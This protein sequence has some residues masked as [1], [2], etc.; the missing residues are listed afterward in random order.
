MVKLTKYLGDDNRKHLT[1][2]MVIAVPIFQG[3][4][5]ELMGSEHLKCVLKH[6]K[7]IHSNHAIL[8]PD[9]LERT[10]RHAGFPSSPGLISRE[11]L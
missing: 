6:P 1:F 9:L 4:I 5:A 8:W 11:Y 7:T 3:L 10:T 2:R